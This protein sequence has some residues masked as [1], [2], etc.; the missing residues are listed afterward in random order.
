MNHYSFRNGTTVAQQDAVC[1]TLRK[2][3][4]SSYIS[5][6]SLVTDASVAAIAI[7]YGTATVMNLRDNTFDN[8]GDAL[9]AAEITG[10]TVITE[11]R[12]GANGASFEVY[13]LADYD[14]TGEQAGCDGGGTPAGVR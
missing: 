9:D 5:G 1:L 3:G 12:R 6:A 13:K 2:A 7:T 10:Q 11:I 14:T 8:E 4:F